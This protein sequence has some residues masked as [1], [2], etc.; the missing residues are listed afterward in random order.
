[1]EKIIC[2]LPKILPDDVNFNDVIILKN[3]IKKS[4]AAFENYLILDV[5]CNKDYYM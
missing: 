5:S 2:Y 1:M 3:K 4:I